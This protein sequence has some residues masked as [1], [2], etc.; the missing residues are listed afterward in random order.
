[1]SESNQPSPSPFWKIRLGILLLLFAGVTAFVV[2]VNIEK[3]PAILKWRDDMLQKLHIRNP[4]ASEEV[5]FI[6]ADDVPEKLRKEDAEICK[7]IEDLGILVVR[8]SATRMG[9]AIHIREGQGSEKLFQLIR[10]LKYLNAL[11]ADGAQITDDLCRYLETQKMLRS[12]SFGNNPITS[13][14]L[15]SLCQM[16]MVTGLYL[17]GT[18]LTGEN[19]EHLANLK[20]LKI[21]DLSGTKLTNEDMKKIAQVKSIHWLLLNDLG[22]DDEGMLHLSQMPELRHLT[23]QKGNHISQEAIQKMRSSSPNDLTID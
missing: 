20:E 19:L 4:L 2:W 13:A 11:N 3:P 22:I 16:E 18:E 5:I 15:P 7:A 10:Q 21:M 23:I 17:R 1:M 6:T 9:N 14:A 12:L 8:D